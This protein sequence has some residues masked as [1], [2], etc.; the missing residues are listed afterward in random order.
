MPPPPPPF[1]RAVSAT[2]AATADRSVVDGKKREPIGC[3]LG[4]A[5]R[6]RDLPHGRGDLCLG[7]GGHFV[8]EN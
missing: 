7:R 4:H 1:L 5:G 3:G 6:G 2:A 8:F